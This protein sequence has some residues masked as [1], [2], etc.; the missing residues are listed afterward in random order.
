MTPRPLQVGEE[1][2]AML[3]NDEIECKALR[4]AKPKWKAKGRFAVINTFADFTMAKLDRAEITAWLLLWRD[5]RPDGLARTSQADLASRAGCSV[6][7]VNRAVQSLR[8]KGLLAVV[9][10]GGLNRNVSVYRVS[11]LAKPGLT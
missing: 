8:R 9:H 5:T 2:Q 1:P 10:Q 3:S 11:P 6:R 7:Q 4:Q